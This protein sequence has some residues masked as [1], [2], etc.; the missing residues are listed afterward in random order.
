MVCA[1][2]VVMIHTGRIE[3]ET[4]SGPAV[5]EWLAGERVDDISATDGF[6][7]SRKAVLERGVLEDSRDGTESALPSDKARPKQNGA[8]QV[9]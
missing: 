4:G 3:R 5:D 7:G 1:V 9:D 6:Q 8:I 2:V